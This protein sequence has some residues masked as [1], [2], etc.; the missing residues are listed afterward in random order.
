M[1]RIVFFGNERLA[2]GVTTECH[3]LK[4]LLAAGHEITAVVTNYEAA[5]SRKS[6]E[7]EVQSVAQAH[8]IPVLFPSKVA[9]IADELLAMK[10]DVGILVAFGQLVPEK[11]I[12]L[13][14]HGIIN[15]HPSL[16]PL[17]RGPTPIESV[18]LDGSKTTGVSIMKLAKA[19]DAGDVYA[20]SV[21]DL[22]GTESKQAL[23]SAALE[24]GA[25][26]IVDLLPEILDGSVAALPQD[27][28]QATYDQKITKQAGELDFN[29]SAEN[30]E[31]EIRAYAEWPKSRTKIGATDVII[32]A[33][34]AVPTNHSDTPGTLEIDKDIPVIMID[35]A[36]GS[37]CIDRLKPAGKNEMDVRSFLAGYTV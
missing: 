10:A 6:R 7:L 31:R 14:P 2:T 9:E 27:H 20:Q 18:I 5:S 30:L 13:F 36:E 24:I 16:L 17:H 15:L 28:P 21:I 19:M 26:M 23:A 1:A 8:S 25:Q 11:I 37:L 12:D 29:K 34:H 22:D 35:T 4:S 33:A 32:T 3:V